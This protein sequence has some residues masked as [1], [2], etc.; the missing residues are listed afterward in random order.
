MAALLCGIFQNCKL[1]NLYRLGLLL[2]SFLSLK[3]RIEVDKNDIPRRLRHLEMAYR[4]KLG[5]G[6]LKEIFVSCAKA[7]LRERNMI[8]A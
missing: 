5:T 7:V 2:F 8:T 3:G 4:T 6:R 1:N